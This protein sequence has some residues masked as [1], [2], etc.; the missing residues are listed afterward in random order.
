MRGGLRAA[1]EPPWPA[2]HVRLGRC[3]GTALRAEGDCVPLYPPPLRAIT[4]CVR[5][6]LECPDV[7]Y[8]N[9]F[10]AE[11]HGRLVAPILPAT[12]ARLFAYWSGVHANQSHMGP[13][14]TAGQLS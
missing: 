4:P 13:S 10:H 11:K 3:A 8:A 6:L 14:R 12:R 2:E 9:W 7:A 5:P 1:H